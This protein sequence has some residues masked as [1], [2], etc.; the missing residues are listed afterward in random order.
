MLKIFCKDNC[1]LNIK[2]FFFNKRF[3]DFAQYDMREEKIL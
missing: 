1:F 3:L 2:Y